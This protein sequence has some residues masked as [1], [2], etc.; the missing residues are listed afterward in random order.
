M[1][2][3]ITARDRIA[4][5]AKAAEA[6]AIATTAPAPFAWLLRKMAAM[7]RWIATETQD[8]DDDLAY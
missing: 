6:E 8:D 3:E 4:A 5:F 7:L 1:T 2:G